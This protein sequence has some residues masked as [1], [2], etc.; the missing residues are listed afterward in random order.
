MLVLIALYIDRPCFKTGTYIW[1]DG[2]CQSEGHCLVNYEAN[3]KNDPAKTVKRRG[4][5]ED[6]LIG[7]FMYNSWWNDIKFRNSAYRFYE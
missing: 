1:T 5:K 3:N 2:M 4:E 6:V 7:V